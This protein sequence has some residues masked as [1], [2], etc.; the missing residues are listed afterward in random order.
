[1]AK[2]MRRQVLFEYNVTASPDN[3]TNRITN[4]WNAMQVKVRIFHLWMHDP[5]VL[6]CALQVACSAAR[7]QREVAPYH[8]LQPARRS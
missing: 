5:C 7:M 4:T 1:M 6:Q 8:S 3:N 2:M